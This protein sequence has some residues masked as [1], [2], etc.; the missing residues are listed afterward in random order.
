[1][2]E[3]LKEL[4]ERNAKTMREQAVMQ[5]E[6]QKEML[7]IE[8]KNAMEL[9]SNVSA[10]MMQGTQVLLTQFMQQQ[11]TL[12]SNFQA[13]PSATFSHINPPFSQSRNHPSQ[14][15]PN[16]LYPSANQPPTSLPSASPVPSAFPMPPTSPAPPFP[17]PRNYQR[18]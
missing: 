5:Q 9:M 6:H 8:H 10:T 13:F 15:F 3:L 2:R 14:G 12:L 11:A 18:F 16:P 17:D 7:Q 4:H 1:M